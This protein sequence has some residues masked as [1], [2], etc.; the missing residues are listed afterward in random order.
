MINKEM[1][2][3]FADIVMLPA[4]SSNICSRSQCNVYNEDGMLPLI[5][6]PM[7]SVVDKNNISLFV[8]QKIYGSYPRG[9]EITNPIKN[10][11]VAYGLDEF[12]KKYILNGFDKS[13]SPQTPHYVMIDIANGHMEKLQNV[14][15]NA[16]MIYGMEELILMVG[17]IAHPKTYA[18]LAKSGANYVRC[19]IGVGSAC[20]SSANT[21]IHYPLC[22][23]LD[24]CNTIREHEGYNTKIV[25]DGGF[26]N[27]DEIIKALGL[28]AD[29]V[30]SGSLFNKA[31]ESSGT[32]RVKGSNCQINQYSEE[33]KNSF[34]NGLELTKEYYGMSTKRA[35]KEMGHEL[36]KTAEG[37]TKRNT[38]EYTIEQ[39]VE[40]FIHYLKSAMSYTG[41]Q[42]IESFIGGVDFQV[43]TP[44]AFQ[45]F[46]K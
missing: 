11:F 18:K 17:N 37:I 42:N 39:W 24:E 1:K 40:N 46:I 45:A 20:T 9:S 30:M 32:T 22:S 7:Y 27:F 4:I 35:Q 25:A 44:Q 36:L 16:R 2:Y 21:S 5:T 3:A 31:L 29:L 13:V 38:V 6:S 19:G 43:I 15:R 10:S 14:I 41:K 33:I 23:L 12:E 8:N 34:K 28:G 26:K